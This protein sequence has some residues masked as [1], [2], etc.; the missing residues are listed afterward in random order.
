MGPLSVI[1]A[2]GLIGCVILLEMLAGCAGRRINTSVSDQT[3]VPGL[4]PRVDAPV[5]EQAKVEE[6]TVAPVVPVP[7]ASVELPKGEPSVSPKPPAATVAPP[8]PARVEEARV[9][10]EPM[11]PAPAVQ[12]L[13]LADVYFDF[14]QYTVRTEAQAVLEANARAL[15]QD[16]AVKIMIEGHCDE[17]GTLAYNM[18]LG[19]R[20]AN[21]AKR[22]LQELG[23]PASQLETVSYGKERPFCAEHSE[24]C[25]QSNRRA[26]FRKP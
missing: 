22:Y 16:R 2:T 3:F 23:V 8:A 1:R 24:A 6:A 9:A 5:V 15:K 14:D 7:P 25:W 20:R 21:A 18:V 17:R 13:S 10:E 4:S 12:P 26:H 11:A 19:E